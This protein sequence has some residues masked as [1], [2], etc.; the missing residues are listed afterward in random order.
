MSTSSNS[1]LSTMTVNARLPSCH[2]NALCVMCSG[3]VLSSLVLGGVT[4]PKFSASL[5]GRRGFV[6]STSVMPPRR[7]AGVP[8]PSQASLLMVSRSPRKYGVL[9]RIT[10]LPSPG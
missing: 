9:T 6:T 4:S 5:T 10:W 3:L 7:V 2:E 8:L 1:S